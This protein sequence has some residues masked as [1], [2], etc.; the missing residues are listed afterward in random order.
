MKKYFLV[1]LVFILSLSSYAQDNSMRVVAPSVVAMGEPFKVEFKLTTE[2]ESFEM[3]KFDGFDLVAGPTSSHMTSISIINGKRTNSSEYNYTCVLIP[4]KKGNLVIGEAT[5]TVNGNTVKSRPLYVEVVGEGAS[6]ARSGVASSEEAKRS[7]QKDDMLL[8]FSVDKKT[9]Y[10][11]EPIIATL[12]LA[13]RVELAGIE[14]AKYPSFNGFWTQEIQLPDNMQWDRENINDKIYETRILKRYL[15]FPQ[16]S[17]ELTVEQMSMDIVA[18][19][20]V[21][22]PAQRRSIFDDFFGGGGSIQNITRKITSKPILI[23]VQDLPKNAP[24]SFDGAVGD[25]SI[26]AKLS[27]DLIS[28]N[29]SG[30]IELKISG[31]GNLPLLTEPKLSLP[32]SFEIYKTKTNDQYTVSANGASGSKVFEYPFIARASGK[33]SIPSVEF[34]YFDTK[35]KNYKTIKTPELNLGVSVDTTAN[36]EQSTTKIF[37]GVTKEELKILGSD[38]RYIITDYPNLHKKGGF[39][40]WSIGY[41]FILLVLL[42]AFA[43]AFV[44]LNKKHKFN[45]DTVRVRSSKARKIALNRLKGSKRLMD[46]S[47]NSLFYQEILKT[48]WGY[49]SDKLNIELA[50][51]SKNNISD[52]LLSKGVDE[53]TVTEYLGVIEQ[54]EFAQY[55][56]SGSSPMSEIYNKSIN[57]IINLEE[58]L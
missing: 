37:T 20:M 51:L 23:K 27:N 43:F 58:K 42:V 41:Y 31:T 29:T 25:Y 50:L 48:M 47:Q 12:K 53:Q 21:N 24:A 5:A 11:G 2:P 17:G 26:S 14:G 56:P 28:A 39:F 22:S 13:T 1:L 7:I 32:N 45:R 3:P 4:T 30:N 44:Y 52:A 18:R 34:S 15:L 55:A 6:S 40:V 16:R 10:N 36:G 46:N 8:M 49:V 33:Y 38:I 9:V 57:V 54:C 19:I 35:S